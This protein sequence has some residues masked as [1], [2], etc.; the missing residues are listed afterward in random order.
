MKNSEFQGQHFTTPPASTEITSSGNTFLTHTF[1]I[2][3][4]TAENILNRKQ[5]NI[6]IV[7]YCNIVI[8]DRFII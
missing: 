5:Y 1:Y 3:I 2:V 4:T 8:Y 6:V 7:I